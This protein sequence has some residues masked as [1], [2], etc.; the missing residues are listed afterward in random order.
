MSGVATAWYHFHLMIVMFVKTWITGSGGTFSIGLSLEIFYV[1]VQLLIIICSHQILNQLVH[2]L[3]I[4]T[5]TMFK[6]CWSFPK[7]HVTSSQTPV[8]ALCPEMCPEIQDDI[9]QKAH[10]FDHDSSPRRIT[11]SCKYLHLGKL[12]VKE[13]VW[14]FIK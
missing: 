6:N 8:T 14:S 7:C 5:P 2:S 10:D 11:L 12:I 9:I 4:L 3:N 1:M 13:K